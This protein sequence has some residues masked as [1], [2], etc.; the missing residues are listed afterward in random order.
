MP[1]VSE[2][3]R[4]PDFKVFRA[5]LNELHSPVPW[6][7]GNI[8]LPTETEGQ[9]ASGLVGTAYNCWLT[10]T[11]LEV[12]KE[13][14]LH[15]EAM[16]GID[17]FRAYG[18][19]PYFDAEG[20]VHRFSAAQI[21]AK[22]LLH[23]SVL[24][25]ALPRAPWLSDPEIES[26]LFYAELEHGFRSSGFEWERTSLFT[27]SE[28]VPREL[29]KLMLHTNLLLFSGPPILNPVFGYHGDKNS[30][31]A[32]GDLIT[33]ATLVEIKSGKK[34][35]W[36]STLRQ[37]LLY[38]ALNQLRSHSFK[39]DSLAAYYPRYELWYEIGMDEFCTKAQQKGLVDLVTAFVSRRKAPPAARKKPNKPRSVVKKRRFR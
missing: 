16:R 14:E 17:L 15:V 24:K 31:N 2:I 7:G 39:I 22:L 19:R 26:L 13:R 38:W 8:K 32:D 30:I 21:E 35:G 4:N 23:S 10:L 25:N 1:T 5:K 20:K 18:D 36:Q 9:K 28:Q 29:R 12:G 3:L 27:I 11:L 6:P 33:G 37:L 34:D